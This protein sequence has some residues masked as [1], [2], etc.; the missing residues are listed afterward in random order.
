[1]DLG[2]Y[3]F[4]CSDRAKAAEMYEKL[5]SKFPGSQDIDT[6]KS[7]LKNIKEDNNKK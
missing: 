4:R 2:N 6:Y 7:F 1:M 3:Y 5:V